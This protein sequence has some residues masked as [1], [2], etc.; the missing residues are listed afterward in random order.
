MVHMGY[1]YSLH[2]RD[3]VRECTIDKR[4]MFIYNH[5]NEDK[6]VLIL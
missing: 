1:F 3:N 2:K 4:G 6:I 5:N